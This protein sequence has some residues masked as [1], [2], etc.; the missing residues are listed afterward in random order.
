MDGHQL[1]SALAH[2]SF[3][4]LWFADTV[5]VTLPLAVNETLE[6]TLLPI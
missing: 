1:Q 5:F 2:L 3:P 4:K 6:M